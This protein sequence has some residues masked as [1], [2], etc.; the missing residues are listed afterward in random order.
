MLQYKITI[1][2]LW[3]QAHAT[4]EKTYLYISP[5]SRINWKTSDH[6]WRSLVTWLKLCIALWNRTWINV[7]KMLATRCT[8]FAALSSTSITRSIISSI[9]TFAIRCNQ[10]RK[11]ERERR[12]G[13]A[14]YFAQYYGIIIGSAHRAEILNAIKR[15]PLVNTR[16]MR[17][18]KIRLIC[19]RGR[20]QK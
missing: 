14:E 20:R 4:F 18:R 9:V 1:K 17:E 19:C 5:L 10:E 2:S 15:F 7:Y 8:L 6:P 12:G 13:G 3:W 16:R 11:R